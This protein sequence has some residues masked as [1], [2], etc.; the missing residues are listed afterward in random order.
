MAQ[1]KIVTVLTCANSAASSILNISTGREQELHHS[2]RRDRL[3]TMIR[4]I[5]TVISVRVFIDVYLP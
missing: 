4:S 5:S 2:D 3:I 1:R